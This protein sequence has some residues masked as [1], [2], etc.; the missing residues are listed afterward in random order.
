[1]VLSGRLVGT[2]IRGI[3]EAGVVLN[4]NSENVSKSLTMEENL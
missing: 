4:R 3:P 2:M 1:M